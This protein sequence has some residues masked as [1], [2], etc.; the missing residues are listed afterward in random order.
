MNTL[1][2]ILKKLSGNIT[3]EDDHVLILNATTLLYE[4]KIFSRDCSST[5]GLESQGQCLRPLWFRK[6]PLTAEHL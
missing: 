3:H 6:R 2:A 4:L 5:P 1:N